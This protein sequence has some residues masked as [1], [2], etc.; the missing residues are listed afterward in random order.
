MNNQVP[1]Q[2]MPGW[3]GGPNFPGNWPMNGQGGCN[4]REQLNQ[5]ENRL[6]RLER[7][8]RRLENRISRLENGYPVP[9]TANANNDQD[10][11]SYA[12]NSNMYMM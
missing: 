11:G 8:V 7:Q 10:F 5:M 9:Y 6:N 1:Y 4:C 2:F 12:N 3:Q